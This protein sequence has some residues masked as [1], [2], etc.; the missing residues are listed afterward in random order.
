MDG[1]FNGQVIMSD[2][3]K[4]GLAE[5]SYVVR[6]RVDSD[7]GLTRGSICHEESGQQIHFQSGDQVYEFVQSFLVQ[8]GLDFNGVAKDP[9]QD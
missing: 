5:G 2:G 1:F 7:G 4:I 3:R 8:D 6:V 9:S